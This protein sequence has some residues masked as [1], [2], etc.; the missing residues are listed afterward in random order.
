ML[1][2]DF[3]VEKLYIS[4]SFSTDEKDGIKILMQW[5]MVDCQK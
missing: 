5:I 4:T 2:V 1:Y 3:A